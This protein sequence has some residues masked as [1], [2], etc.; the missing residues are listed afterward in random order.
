MTLD[1]MKAL[2]F[3]DESQQTDD[4]LPP[5]STNASVVYIDN[6]VH[7]VE[8]MGTENPDIHDD[9]GERCLFTAVDI[10]T[11][12]GGASVVTNLS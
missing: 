1:A 5:M 12:I 7:V 9:D 3:G 2:Q 4:A 6:T 8:R 11:R 10:I